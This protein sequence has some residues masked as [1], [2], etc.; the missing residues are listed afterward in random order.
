[1]IDFRVLGNLE[2]KRPEGEEILSVL[3][4]PKRVALL[5]YL[6]LATAQGFRRRDTII[7]LF[8][9]EMDQE[10][11]RGA[12]RK[13]LYFLRKSMGEEVL[14]GRGDEELALD[15]S[16]ITCDAVEFESAVT[17]GNLE[18]ALELYR[19]D[20]LDGVFLSGCPEFEK[21]LDGERER[22][23]EMAAGAAWDL[24][25][26]YLALG[27]IT[28][29]E[30]MAQR[31]LGL[32][33]TDENEVQGFIRA[34]SDAGDR[35]AAVRFYEKFARELEESLELRPGSETRAL[36]EEIRN[37][38]GT[39]FPPLK[40][41]GAAAPQD[42][43]LLQRV[44]EALRPRYR[45]EREIGRGGMATVLL[46]EDP[47]HR[48]RVAVKVLDPELA[49]ALG[50]ERFLHEIEIAANLTH[51]HILP[52]FDSGEA[53][54]LLY[55]VMPYVEGES[56][57]SRLDRE[58][59]LSVED[60]VAI[61]RE[62]AGA[63]GFAHERGVVHRDVK[64]GNILLE[65]GHAVLAD[66]G[67][68]HALAL[69]GEM[70]HTRTGVSLGTPA[71]M[72]PEQSAGEADLDGRSDEYALAC[73]LY[74]MLAGD[75]PFRGATGE[76]V[77]RQHLTRDPVAITEL[78]PSVPR[79]VSAALHR[80][81]AKTPAD[82]FASMEEFSRA[83]K[84]AAPHQSHQGDQPRSRSLRRRAW[85][86]GTLGLVGVVASALFLLSRFREAPPPPAPA[87]PGR[88]VLAIMPFAI[89]GPEQLQWLSRGMASVLRT[90]LDDVGGVRTVDLNALF[91][92]VGRLGP[93]ERMTL[94]SARDA[95][96]RFGATHFTLGDGVGAGGGRLT[97]TATLYAV[98]GGPEEL[99]VV[100]VEGSPDDPAALAD[101][102]AGPVLEGLHV[103]TGERLSGAA[104][105]TT[106]S[107]SATRAWLRGEEE[108]RATRYDR[109]YAAFQEAVDID[110]TF[111]LAQYRLSVAAV[112]D[113]RFDQA[114]NA[115]DRAWANSSR[116]T[117]RDRQLLEAWA[118]LIRGSADRAE[119]LY[120]AILADHPEEVEA[121]FGLGTV[122]VYF[123]PIR[124]LSPRE[125]EGEFQRVLELSPG[126]GQAR[127]H[128]LEFATMRRDQVAFDSL[129]A[130]V[131]PESDQALAWA[132]VRALGW[133]NAEDRRRIEDRI[134]VADPVQGGLAVARVAAYLQD[135]A[136]A[137]RL[138]FLLS[139]PEQDSD[140]R[141]AAHLLR[142][143]T[144]LAQ[145]RW[146]EAMASLEEAGEFNPAWA[147]ELTAL[148]TG[149]PLR[150][151]DQTEVADLRHSLS[152]WDADQEGLS[153]NFVLFAHNGYHPSLRLYLLALSSIWAGELS[154]AR[155]YASELQT[156]PSD[157][158]RRA[159]TAAWA[160]SIRARIAAREGRTADAVPQLASARADVPLELIAISP[161]FSR[162][163]DRY[164]LGEL[165]R[166]LGRDEEALT[167]FQT[168]TE[169]HELMMVAPAHLRM[170]EILEKGGDSVAAAAHY[171]RFADLWG[172]ADPE[173]Q[174]LVETAR[175][176]ASLLGGTLE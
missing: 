152:A 55:Y 116:L 43:D 14:R 133:G 45:V 74:E 151:P 42:R 102:L 122:R 40:P 83:L 146:T 150:I 156:R 69:A 79:R 82:R 46:A 125:A 132:A 162:S 89:Q 25:N 10:R 38:L 41:D 119:I 34:L 59:Q 174:P 29:G 101:S 88:I 52:L 167:W 85:T 13:S 80:A 115:A 105:R 77:A 68:A 86:L 3:S 37:T 19:G 65:A 23:R 16:E 108:F 75:Q 73:V 78:R 6:A 128:L 137:E 95:A 94:T 56:L 143:M 160:T 7:G 21:W 70:R 96:R 110:P 32:V 36:A 121:H 31:A 93:G 33:P 67:V 61:T 15:W 166:E 106:D 165:L 20:L 138:A 66:F 11:A 90:R 134:R 53:D 175:E 111:A 63:L 84:E 172:H 50:A 100:S 30:R 91:P 92:Y 117:N 144:R 158:E 60:A 123:N 126:Y 154:D 104:A 124:G 145:G 131:D 48:R 87:P 35:A 170:A 142:A 139:G 127:F 129:F 176:K 107:A 71:Y 9:S 103:A 76:S 141:A 17:T 58:K 5:A 72:S 49:E 155:E 4:Q 136:G 149:F 28:E 98:E 118:A 171:S 164:A 54:G 24:A 22:L 173:F 153:T 99:K 163:F 44:R 130:G 57:R 148:F 12:L 135:H 113:L 97:L 39:P 159:V 168:L 26:R 112:M 109:A 114:H 81:M 1:V 51:P 157:P 64:P 169:G 147:T 120:K 47:K 161:F 27:R 62:I 18:R 140:T 2:L 8:W